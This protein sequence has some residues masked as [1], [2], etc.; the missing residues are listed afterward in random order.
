MNV[1][2]MLFLIFISGISVLYCVSNPEIFVNGNNVIF[3]NQSIMESDGEL[4]LSYFEDG[5]LFYSVRQLNNEEL[6]SISITEQPLAEPDPPSLHVFENGKVLIIY[7][8]RVSGLQYKAILNPGSEN[9]EISEFTLNY[10]NRPLIQ[11]DDEGI[12]LYLDKTTV[13]SGG[14]FFYYTQTQ[15]TENA[16]MYQDHISFLGQDKFWGKVHSNGDIHL[17]ELSG[18]P[19]FNDITTTSGEFIWYNGSPAYQ[20]VFLSEYAENVPEIYFK[21][22][23][24]F[25]ENVSLPF[26]NEPSEAHEIIYVKLDGTEYVSWYGDIETTR[27]DTIAVW[28]PNYPYPPDNP[29]PEEE[30]LGYNYVVQKDT[31]WTPGPSASVNN[32]AIMVYDELW[33]EGMVSGNQTWICADSIYITDDLLYTNTEPG[34]SPDGIDDSGEFTGAINSTDFLNL[35][36]EERIYIKYA[37]YDPELDQIKKPNCSDIYLYGNFFATGDGGNAPD[38]CHRDGIISFEYQHPH[39]STEPIV[40]EDVT[41][42][43]VDL[44]R[45]SLDETWP[46]DVDYPYYNPIWPEQQPTYYRGEIHLFGSTHQIRSGFVHRSGSDPSNHDGTWDLDNYKYGSNHFSCGYSKSYQFDHRFRIFDPLYHCIYSS[47]ESGF[48]KLSSN[49]QGDSFEIT[50][51]TNYPDSKA[52]DLNKQLLIDKNQNY[53]VILYKPKQNYILFSD[54]YG[55]DYNEIQVNENLGK[56]KDIS[57][58]SDGTVFFSKLN[59]YADQ[60]EILKFDGSN[61][62]SIGNYDE[63]YAVDFCKDNEANL[64]CVRYDRNNTLKVDRLNGDSS[65][66]FTQEID[67]LLTSKNGEII[68]RFDSSDSLVVFYRFLEEGSFPETGYRSY[69]SIINLEGLTSIGGADNPKAGLSI[70]T[71]PNPYVISAKREIRSNISFNLPR[72]SNIDLSLFNIKGQKIK[73]IANRSFSKGTHEL[74]WNGKNDRGK[75]VT[76]GIYFYRLKTEGT[77]RIKKLLM[78]K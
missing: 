44:H 39:S 12:H 15:E 8:N 3:D 27:T 75:S 22:Y 53:V 35:I 25:A 48:L 30:P 11:T 36:S 32:Q 16:D 1:K 64:Y 13:K 54:N 2:L 59:S 33:I 34:Q 56:T 28:G 6:L 38:A 51:E 74:S 17:R 73:T 4:H 9:F 45:Y 7:T 5:L 50:D 42:D 55:D 43:Q 60:L 77:T 72:H 71:W 19:L 29:D 70:E 76:S 18:W 41:Y 10:G 78:L 26:G 21:N 47:S 37:N 65:W 52:L 57:V 68:T 46:S 14:N 58:A 20:Q 62:S 40:Y 49:N 61:I 67:N 23:E 24:E 66:E 63:I 31:I 69:Y